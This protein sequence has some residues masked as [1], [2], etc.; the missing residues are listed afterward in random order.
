MSDKGRPMTIRRTILYSMLAIGALFMLFLGTMMIPME[1]TL[2]P[3]YFILKKLGWLD[4]YLALI[5][6]WGASVF[7]IFL[8]RQHMMSLP[9]ELLEQA[10]IDG[11]SQWQILWIIVFPMSKPV[12]VSVGIFSM[13]GS[14]N[15][16]LWPLIMTSSQN[17]YTL[18]VGLSVFASEFATRFNLMMA[19]AVLATLPVVA[20]YFAAQRYFNE[21]FAMTVER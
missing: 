4:T 9:R 6:P 21:G 3:N 15:A 14:W 10:E 13:L 5:V 8:I 19:A 1:V 12:F 20:V 7:G 2:I 17:M 16:F 18:P 11:C